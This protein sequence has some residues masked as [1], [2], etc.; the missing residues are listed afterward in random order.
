MSL[1]IGFDMDGVFA[2][3]ASAFHDVEVRL[4]GRDAAIKPNDPEQEEAAE[5]KAAAAGDTLE[6]EGPPS[7]RQLRR[8]RDAVWSAIRS[9]RDFWTTLEPLDPGAVRRLDDLATRHRWEVFFMTQ[10]PETEGD[11]VQRQTQR[12]LV[13]QGFELP[14]VLVLGGSRGAAAAALRL[15]YHVDDSPQHCVDIVSESHARPILVLPDQDQA[16]IAKAK[17]L[18]I[19]TARSIAGCLDLLEEASLSRAQPRLLN[20]LA[21]MV[22]WK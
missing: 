3:F 6:E 10:R 14:S 22:G 19:G 11:T 7:P 4:F 8:R 21:T 5:A 1:R 15:D 18:R 2:D 20:R 16:T 12:W 13:Q 17:K 9:T